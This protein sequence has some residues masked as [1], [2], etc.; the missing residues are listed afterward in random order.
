MALELKPNLRGEDIHDKDRRDMLVSYYENNFHLIPCGSKTDIVPDYFKRRHPNEEDDVIA[1]RWS[2]TPR[3]KWSEYITKQPSIQEIK[4]WYLQFPNCNWAVVTGISFV[5]LDADTQEACDF[6]ESG[7]LTRTTLKQKTPRGGYHYFYAIN[8]S[9]T[10][11]NTTGR[12]DIRGEG[13]YVMVSP[14]DHYM[15]E[16]VD[17]LGVDSM[18]DLPTLSAQDMNVIYDFNNNNKIISDHNMSLS[19][20]GVQSGMRNDTLARLVGKWILEGWGMREVIIK[21]LDWNQTNT[22]PM[23]VQE[24]LQT[25]NSICTGHL[26]RNPHDIDAGILKWKTSQWQIPLADELKEIMDQDDPIDVAKAIHVVEKD[27]LGLKK[28]NDPFWD[29]MDSNR[30]EQFWGD[31]FVFEQSR[32]LLLGKPKIG[33]SHWLGAFAASATT[34]T[35]FMGKQFS[36]PMKVMW[37]QAEIIHEFLK[38]RIEMYYKP[39]HHDPE[40]YNLGKSNL[41]ASGRLRRNIMRDSDMD[42][43]AQSI[44]FHK[45]DLVMIDPIINFF[46]GEENSNSEIH[47]MLSRIDRLI[48]LFGVAV[49]IA[50][51]TGK[52]RA[53]DLSFMS[54]RGGSAFA[55]WMDSGVKLSGTKPNVTLFYEARNARE[56]DQHLAYFD[57]ERGFFRPVSVSDAPDEVEVARVVAGAMSS[58]KFYTRQDLELL[59]RQ[60]LKEN[61]L[62]SGERAARYAVSHVQ[63]YLGEKVKT[64][65]I[66]GKNTWYYLEDNQMSRPWGEDDE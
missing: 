20:D 62:A 29:T 26:K 39:F 53:D 21:A 61:E 32:V 60:A 18:D 1:K 8:D 11:R 55:G 22:P 2:K 24:V 5:V 49:I 64:H 54:A 42:D 17:G 27:P 56:P 43:I 50:H 57:F 15:F 3:V 37:L 59:A 35:E 9:L 36:R 10:I 51:H 47:E 52:E 23:S 6:V 28:F 25:A 46:S 45:P 58:Y 30:I 13:G 41:V 65:S 16:L 12:L 31:A 7:Q 4:Q 34:G 19:L 38:K 66:P 63:K 44:E 14:S 48:E 33:K 40:L